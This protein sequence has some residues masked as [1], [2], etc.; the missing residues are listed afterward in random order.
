MC[1]I[2]AIPQGKQVDKSILKRCWQ[3]NPH[4][5]GYMYSTGSK[6]EVFKELTSFKNLWRNFCDAKQKHIKSSFVVHFRISTH[7]KINEANC[8]PFL[9][10][11]NLGFAHNG[12]IGAAPVNPNFSD[13]Y[14][15][16]ETILKSLPNNF[17]NNVAQVSLITQ[18]IGS[19][20]KLAFLNTKGEIILINEK[21]G[22]WDNGVWY[23]N[24][25]YKAYDYYDY[26]GTRVAYGGYA[27]IAKPY[28]PTLF[29]NKKVETKK[30]AKQR[31]GDVYD[32]CDIPELD[33]YGNPKKKQVVCDYC[34]EALIS[35]WERLNDCCK[36]CLDA[37]LEAD[38]RN[39][40]SSRDW[41]GYTH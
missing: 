23:S 2:V 16:N 1:I 18:Y 35:S 14:M 24:S 40:K 37:Q 13:T 41:F 6:V 3:N 39:A 10:N 22:V 15:F 12:I 17:I 30:E 29:E 32:C 7:G 31:N 26:G 25:G 28:A 33:W 4:G 11:K 9:V 5:A 27:P 21:A 20:S 8:H 19:G 34:G 38:S 36:T